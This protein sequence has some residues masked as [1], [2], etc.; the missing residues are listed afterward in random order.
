[1]IFDATTKSLEVVLGG[2]I[3]TNQ[4]EIVADWVD[5]T[6]S[7][8]TPGNTGSVTNNTTA[9]TAVAAPAAST[10]RKITGLSIY[11]A[12]TVAQ[13]VTVRVNDNSTMRRKYKITLQPGYTLNY[14]DVD[15]WWVVDANGFVQNGNTVTFSVPSTT[16]AINDQT[17]T[18]Y[19][20]GLGDAGV[21]VRSTNASNITHT[22]P[23]NASVAFP[24]YTFIFPVQGGAGT[25]TVAAAGGVTLRAPN[26]ASTGAQYDWRGL[27][28]TGTNE[29]TVI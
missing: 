24:L 15:G 9:V 11:Q 16:G 3:T 21:P 8:T 28:K 12:D 19:T 25:I 7:A 29:W 22:V 2:S 5:M 14:S 23:T 1:M 27:Y 6:S 4:L 18:T 20:Y 13:V 26:G 10:V 17:G